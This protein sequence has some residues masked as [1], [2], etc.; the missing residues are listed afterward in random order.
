MTEFWTTN[1]G[2]AATALGILVSLIGLG[3]AIREAHGARSAAQ[4][5]Q[6]AANEAR[7]RMARHLQAVDLQRGIGLIGRIKDLHANNRW[8]AA[9]EHYQ[10]LREMLSD[11]IVR[12]PEEKTEFRQKLAIA[13]SN[14]TAMDNRVRER[15]AEGVSEDDRSQFG[16]G[17]NDIQSDLEELASDLGF[18]DAPGGTA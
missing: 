18:G 12:C 14:I 7:D 16:Q 3:W 10:T 4:A 11:V 8:E 9:T 17:L 6:I 13:R 15:G 1:W 5:A 2:D